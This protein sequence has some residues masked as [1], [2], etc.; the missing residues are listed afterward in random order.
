[1]DNN[2]VNTITPQ[3]AA[4]I[5][6]ILTI[7]VLAIF[8]IFTSHSYSKV[9]A[10]SIW[11]LTCISMIYFSHKTQKILDKREQI[12]VVLAG[13]G[14]CIFSFLNI[15]LGLGNPPFSIGEF[16]LLLSGVSIVVFGLLTFKTLILPV[17]FP[18]IA[19]LGFELY[20]LFIRHEDW[21][22]A[23]LI[24]PTITLTTGI[25][26]LMGID[27]EVNGNI[28]S[29]LSISGEEIRL[30]VVSDCTGIWSLGTFTVASIIVLSTF[31]EAISKRGALL[32]LVGYVGTYASNIGRIAIISL[33]GY[34]YGPQGVIEQ[35]HVH[36]GWILFSLWMVVFWYYFFTRHLGF[37][38]VGKKKQTE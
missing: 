32:I 9:D 38:L 35:V 33:S 1:M 25:I 26:R 24:P 21:L 16:S 6:V 14:V 31:P 12:L 19:V 5:W 18:V 17:L 20:E 13:I 2:P 7:S 23:P 15:P 30:A 10:I 28:I 34:I 8:F 22:I 37:S 27:S 3:K 36:T 29:F 11:I 4:K